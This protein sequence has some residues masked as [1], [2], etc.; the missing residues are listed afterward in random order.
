LVSVI[1]VTGVN[2]NEAEDPVLTLPDPLGLAVSVNVTVWF[3][4]E[5][6]KVPDTVPVYPLLQYTLLIGEF[7]VSPVIDIAVWE[8]CVMPQLV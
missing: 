3:P 4:F 2:V 1:D 7:M 5:K 6:V 8:P